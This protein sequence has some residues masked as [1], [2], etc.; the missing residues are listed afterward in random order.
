MLIKI[1]ANIDSVCVYLVQMKQLK[2]QN[3]TEVL[4]WQLTFH[5]IVVTYDMLFQKSEQIL[6]D[7]LRKYFF[8]D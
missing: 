5:K 6:V 1:Q 3:D 7:L 4:Y 8:V 2:M